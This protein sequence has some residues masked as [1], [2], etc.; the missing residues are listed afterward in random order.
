MDPYYLTHKAKEV[1]YQPEVI[2][3]GR[4]INDGMGQYTA[5]QLVKA[6]SRRKI[7]VDEARVLV[8]GFT[9]KGDCPDVRNTKIIDMITELESF[10]MKVDVFDGW[11]DPA[12]VDSA[13]GIKLVSDLT[14]GVYDAIVLAVDHS[15]FKEWGEENIRALG[16]TQHVLYDVKH[17][18]LPGQSDLRL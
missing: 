12:E 7:H 5:T 4:R 1:G 15:E 14:D 16:K 13:Y 9:F 18:L 3:A 8:L 17:V 2:L 6:L 11:A 10:Y